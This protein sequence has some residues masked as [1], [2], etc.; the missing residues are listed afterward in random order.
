MRTL[1]FASLIALC[2]CS[3]DPLR[4]LRADEETAKETI[5][6]FVARGEAAVPALKSAIEDPDPAVRRRVKTALGRI[7]GQ[8]GG[9]GRLV[10]KRC[11]EE[12]IGHG[13]PILVLQLFGK[14]DEEFC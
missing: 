11:L 12:A 6:G 13:K 7:T 10:W 2:A 5:A 8:W 4:G 1:A 3:Q 14:L 9:D